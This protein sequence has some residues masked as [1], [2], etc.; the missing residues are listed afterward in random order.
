MKIKTALTLLIL[1]WSSLTV[2]SAE[3]ASPTKPNIL[4]IVADD[5]ATR[6]GCYGDAAAI[7]PN[8]DRQATQGMVFQKA[9][10]QGVVCT[11]SRT[12]FMLGLNNRSANRDHFRQNP[13]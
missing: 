10:V 9:Y 13:A 8:L 11:P 7:T 6:V 3:T 5:L 12:A 4:F 2:R 1:G